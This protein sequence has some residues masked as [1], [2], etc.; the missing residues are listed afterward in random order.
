M[1]V[2]FW[3][4]VKVWRTSDKALK[5]LKFITEQVA[6]VSRRKS[7]AMP[8]FFI[9]SPVVW[10]ERSTNIRHFDCWGGDD[11]NL[12]S[13]DYELH[14]HYHS[15][16]QIT[17]VGIKMGG[18]APEFEFQNSINCLEALFVFHSTVIHQDRLPVGALLSPSHSLPTHALSVP[19][20]RWLQ[21]KDLVYHC[22]SL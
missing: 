18:N 7:I 16:V 8:L 6:P 10:I 17:V 5:V 15:G 14:W 22:T 13:A 19:L 4:T 3:T 12:G 21:Q 20:L 1:R 11:F 9:K 2:W